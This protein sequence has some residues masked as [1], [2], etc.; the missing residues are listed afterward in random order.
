MQAVDRLLGRSKTD[1][2]RRNSDGHQLMGP[3]RAPVAPTRS[4]PH[5]AAGST[6]GQAP[7]RRQ[8]LRCEVARRHRR[9]RSRVRVYASPHRFCFR[10][11]RPGLAPP[12]GRVRQGRLLP[13]SSCRHAP[14][15]RGVMAGPF[16]LRGG[17]GSQPGTPRPD[18][19]PVCASECAACR[20]GRCTSDTSGCAR[21]DLPAGFHERGRVTGRQARGP[22]SSSTDPS[23]PAAREV[24]RS[25]DGRHG[26]RH[27]TKNRMS[28][29]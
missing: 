22:F 8:R 29:R 14:R 20:R 25:D 11:L 13:R 23:A 26:T 27:A 15:V 4:P 28:T 19:E 6:H 21:W 5:Q 17:R 3:V 10:S 7:D 16:V 9:F 2:V 18:V 24:P 1:K 12:P